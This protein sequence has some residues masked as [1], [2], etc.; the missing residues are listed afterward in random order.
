MRKFAVDE[1]ELDYVASVEVPG[2]SLNQFSMDE[3]DGNFRIA[4]TEGEVWSSAN[5]SSNNLY[6]YDED[7]KPLGDIQNIAP[8][9]SIYSTRFMGD[10]VYMVTFKKVDPFFV[11]DASDPT[12]PEVLGELKIPGYSNYLHPLDENHVIGIGKDTVEPGDDEANNFW[13]EVDF[14]WYQG[15]KMAIFDVTDVE[16]PVELHKEIIGDRGTYSELLY[17]HKAL[18]FDAAKGIMAF[19]VTLAELPESV[20]K[21]PEIPGSAY[22]EYTYQGAYIY[23]VS[24]EDG[25]ELRGT[26]THFDEDQLGNAFEYYYWGSDNMIERILYIGD[27]FY[28]VSEALVRANA[29]DDLEFVNEVEL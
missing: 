7:L 14:A 9:E 3:H 4:T 22:G 19:P 1:T 12:D 25:F 28:T 23:D 26:I 10:R 18:M 24:V 6:I 16:N 17:N 21:D 29:M 13:N 27:Y 2:Y 15:M 8:G 20:A 11:I 5:P